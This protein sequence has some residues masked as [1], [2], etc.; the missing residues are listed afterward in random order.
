[1]A[2]SCLTLKKNAQGIPQ[3]FVVTPERFELSTH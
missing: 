2:F 1:M 3:A